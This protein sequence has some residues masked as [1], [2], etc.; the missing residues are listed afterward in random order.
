MAETAPFTETPG[1]ALPEGGRVEWFTGA[2][3]AR[4]RAAIFTAKGQARGSV[5]LSG[6]R[7]EAIEKYVEVIEDLRAR[8]FVVLTHDWRGQGLSHREL[9]DRLRGHAEGWDAFLGD[10]DALLKTYGDELPKPWLAIGHSMGGCLTLLAL[11]HGQAKHFAG[12]VLSAPMLGVRVGRYPKMVRA[13]VAFNRLTGRGGGYVLN[14]PGKPFDDTFE[15]NVLTHDRVRFARGR[16]VIA[17]NRDLALGGPTWSWLAFALKSADF[18]ARPQNLGQVD[19]PVVI[20]SAE[21]E[22]L[23]DNEAQA[24]AAASL[25][26]GRLVSVKGALHEIL[27]ETDDKRDVFWAEFD[28]LA[29]QVAP[30]PA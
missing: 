11:A 18:F 22:K 4:L 30:R 25:P 27:M 29:D 16:A 3:G 10:F 7:T 2:A 19:I 12:A 9:P 8:G 13:L 6:G 28:A 15:D 26:K 23:V 14:D 17:A 21:Q 5:I 1:A 24:H 20:C